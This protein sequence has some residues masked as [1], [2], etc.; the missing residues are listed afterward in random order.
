MEIPLPAFQIGGG[1]VLFL[2][3][4]TMIFGPT[5][6]ESEKDLK[7]KNM[8]VYVFPL[9]VPCISSPGAMMAAVMLTDNNSFNISKQR[10]TV[11]AFTIVLIITLV[12][13]LF[14]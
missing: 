3:A 7:D 5:K 13:L 1:L 2:F 10:V 9:A 4:L 14:S 11:A 6:P 8:E 12:V